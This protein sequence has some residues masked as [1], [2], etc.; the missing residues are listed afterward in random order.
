MRKHLT[1]ARVLNGAVV[2]GLALLATA[3]WW[4]WLALVGGLV[5]AALA[6]VRVRQLRREQEERLAD[7]Q[8]AAMRS[9]GFPQPIVDAW[10][11]PPAPRSYKGSRRA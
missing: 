10:L 6:V 9:R 2:A 8:A 5:L 1:A 4:P 11:A 3:P 7:M